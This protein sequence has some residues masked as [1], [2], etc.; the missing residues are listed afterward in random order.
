MFIFAILVAYMLGS[1]VFAIIVSQYVGLSDPRA[2][3]SGNPGANNLA[4]KSKSLGI[5]TLVL[6]MIKAFIALWIA[7]YLG[8]NHWQLSWVALAVVIGHCYPIF[9]NF[10]GMIR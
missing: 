1:L 4:R 10:S 5:I 3:G 2:H 7:F 9:Y 6:D 8:C